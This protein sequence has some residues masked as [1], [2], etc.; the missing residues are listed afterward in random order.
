MICL[1]GIEEGAETQKNKA[2]KVVYLDRDRIFEPRQSVYGVGK[3]GAGVPASLGELGCSS[4]QQS[5]WGVEDH[6]L[7]SQGWGTVQVSQQQQKAMGTGKR[8]RRRRAT[9]LFRAH[10]YLA[11]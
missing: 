3:A 2:L 1:H 8:R 7:G 6:V 11:D 9:L 4:M 5:P 10:T